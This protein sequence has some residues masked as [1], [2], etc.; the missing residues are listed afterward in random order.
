[1]MEVLVVFGLIG[2]ERMA[3]SIDG[4]RF[5][6]ISCE[7]DGESF[8]EGHRIILFPTSN[9]RCQYIVSRVSIHPYKQYVM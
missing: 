8:G 7:D 4:D 3:K 6:S 2:N 1:M 5:S 9:I